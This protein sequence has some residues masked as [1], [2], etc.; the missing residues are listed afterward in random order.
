M[1]T[2][3]HGAADARA[4]CLN[5]T[6]VFRPGPTDVTTPS[7]PAFRLGPTDATS[8]ALNRRLE[9]IGSHTAFGTKSDR[10]VTEANA[11]EKPR[12]QDRPRAHE[13]LPTSGALGVSGLAR[14]ATQVPRPHGQ[15]PTRPRAVTPLL[16]AG[17]AASRPPALS[18]EPNAP[19]QPSDYAPPHWDLPLGVTPR[20]P[21]LFPPF[22]PW[23][24]PGAPT[25]LT[26]TTQHQ[27]VLGPSP[28][29]PPLPP[30]PT[31]T[32]TCSTHCG[33]LLPGPDTSPHAPPADSSLC[34]TSSGFARHRTSRR[35]PITCN[36]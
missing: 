25:T 14:P 4:P 30:S 5:H 18:E 35:V 28:R 10:G 32:L 20:P 19:H 23:A 24:F 9:S 1:S 34:P 16:F 29:L 6:P 27:P 11:L 7:K 17:P 33:S 36:V 22:R 13:S 31:P 12:T 15:P 3:R 2:V 21:H 8:L 26:R